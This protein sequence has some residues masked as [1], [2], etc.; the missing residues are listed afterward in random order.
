MAKILQLKISLEGI[1]PRI[2]RRFLVEEN[3]SF[4][5][6]HEIIQRVMGWEDYH[7][8]EFRVGGEI[9]TSREEGFNPAEGALKK[10]ASSPQ[11]LK[12][13][14]QIDLKK[15]S[16]TLDVNKLNKILKCAEKSKA[17]PK[18]DMSTKIGSLVNK[19]GA[20]FH[21]VY[22][23]GDN[24][25]HILTIEKI[26]DDSNVQ[27]MPVCLEGERACPP[28]DCGSIYGYYELQK[29]KKNKK[30]PEYQER[31]IDWLGEDFDFELFDIG[32][33]NKRLKNVLRGKNE[34]L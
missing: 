33:I 25:E 22:D 20:E 2:W 30:H 11:F 4:R 29:I 17:R 3:I 19:E 5:K 6:F 14:E 34:R 15:G 21:Y 9:I 28:E 23:F 31:I 26:F 18:Y 24:W 32:L 13:I 16:A 1:K 7:L 8:Y 27:K 10:I 12:M